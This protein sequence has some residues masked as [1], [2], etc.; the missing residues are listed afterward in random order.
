MFRMPPSNTSFFPLPFTS[1]Y[2][3]CYRSLTFSNCVRWLACVRGQPVTREVPLPWEKGDSP[4]YPLSP[5]IQGCTEKTQVSNLP[6]RCIVSCFS[7]SL[8]CLFFQTLQVK[9]HHII[10]FTVC[11][12]VLA[13]IAWHIHPTSST[14]CDLYTAINKPNPIPPQCS[15]YGSL[16]LLGFLVNF[17]QGHNT[18]S[19]SLFFLIHGYSGFPNTQKTYEQ[20]FPTYHFPIAPHWMWGYKGECPLLEHRVIEESASCLGWRIG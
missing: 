9:A 18:W 12:S 14:G 6:W 20:M 15:T 7:W 3:S 13:L 10:Q 4:A 17:P 1:L 16:V 11:N 8:S 5:I 19:S 2:S